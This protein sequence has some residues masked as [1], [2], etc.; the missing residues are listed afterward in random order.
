MHRIQAIIGGLIRAGE[1]L[2]GFA[3]PDLLGRL[4]PLRTLYV[5]DLAHGRSFSLAT[6]AMIQWMHVDSGCP[7]P[8]V[9]GRA[10]EEHLETI[11]LALPR[12]LNI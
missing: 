6:D 9:G 2:G 4:D 1:R 3:D 5:D 12:R 10:G 7:A 11:A 8:K